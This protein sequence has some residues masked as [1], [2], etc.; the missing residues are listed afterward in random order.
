MKDRPILLLAVAQTLVWA[1]IYYSFPAL[2]LY[3][4]SSLGWSRADLT[5]AVTL[6][7]FVSAFCSPLYGRLIDSGRGAQMMAGASLPGYAGS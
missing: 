7:I 5:A 1:C 6:A 2:L 4:E 3:W